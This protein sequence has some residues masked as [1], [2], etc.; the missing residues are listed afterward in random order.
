MKPSPKLLFLP[1]A[2][3]FLLLYL[4]R[5]GQTPVYQIPEGVTIK[6]VGRISQ[7]PYLKGSNQTISV[8]PILIKTSRFP[9]YF[10]GQKI[11]IIGKFTPQVTGF[12]Q[13]RYLSYFPTIEVVDEAEKTFGWRSWRQSL[14][15]LR[16][17]LEKRVK[18]FLPEPGASLLNGILLGAKQEMPEKFWQNLRKTGTLHVVVASG[19]NVAMVAKFLLAIFVLV[20]SHRKA[21]W[22]SL[23]GV[24]IYVLMVGAEPPVVRA[25]LMVG[26]AYLAQV[27]GREQEGTMGLLWAAAIILLISPLTLFDLG[28][29][30]SFTATAGI[31]WLYPWF[32]QMK[33]F[34]WPVIGEALATTLAAQLGVLPLLLTNF[35]QISLLSP[36][37]NA[38]VLWT[39]PLMMILGSVSLLAGFIIRPLGQVL[40]WLNWPFLTFFI[41]VIEWSAKLPGVSW[42]IGELSSWWAIGYYLVLGYCIGCKRRGRSLDHEDAAPPKAK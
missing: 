2:I 33:L 17:H 30:L 35:G 31:L 32:K 13:K 5:L 10:Y 15:T 20:I 18:N 36:L 11:A 24:L 21:I 19:Q 26:L 40:S 6:V 23:T 12:F 38:L 8:G 37:I 39:V 42:T 41:K 22:L 28:F 14:L 1:L 4:F 25:G 9:G 7:P 16:G 27:F 3:L 29:Q 34:A